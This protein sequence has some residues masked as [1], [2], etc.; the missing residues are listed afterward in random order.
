MDF[1][2]ERHYTYKESILYVKKHK[3]YAIGNG[4]VFLALLFIPILGFIIALPMGAVGGT[5][6]VVDEL[7]K[8]SNI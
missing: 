3:G 5:L 8:Q 6:N 7:K 4:L 1:T 2:L